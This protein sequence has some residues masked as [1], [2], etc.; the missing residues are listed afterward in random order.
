MLKLTLSCIASHIIILTGFLCHL[1]H[2]IQFIN[3]ILDNNIKYLDFK[4]IEP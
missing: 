3:E 1:K 4:T 2:Y